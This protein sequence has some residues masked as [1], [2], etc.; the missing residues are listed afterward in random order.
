M[1]ERLSEMIS[2]VV[3]SCG[4][5]LDRLLTHGDQPENSNVQ[6]SDSTESSQLTSAIQLPA[7]IEASIERTTS[8]FKVSLPS[9]RWNFSFRPTW[10]SNQPNHFYST[11]ADNHIPLD[12]CSHLLLNPVHL[13]LLCC[14]HSVRIVNQKRLGQFIFRIRFCYT[15]KPQ[16]NPR[17]GCAWIVSRILNL[18]FP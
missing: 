15:V 18:E 13:R 7:E 16:N 17:L 4:Q 12:R 11:Q 10:V 5:D 1:N 6:L 9:G 14:S 3:T 2:Q 8:A